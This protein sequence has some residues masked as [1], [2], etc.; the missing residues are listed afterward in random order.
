[1]VLL[2]W[3]SLVYVSVWS[4]VIFWET[5]VHSAYHITLSLYQYLFVNL[6]VDYMFLDFVLILPVMIIA[7]IPSTSLSFH[8]QLCNQ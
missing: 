5:A 3:F 6:V 4:L 8:I 2:L 1:M 7:L